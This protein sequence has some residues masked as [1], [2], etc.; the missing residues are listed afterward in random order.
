VPL[1]VVFGGALVRYKPADATGSS[2]SLQDVEGLT[3]PQLFK[4]MKIPEDQ[5]MLVI[6]NGDIVTAENKAHTVVNDGDNLSLMSPIQA[7]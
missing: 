1:N 6:L 5:P 7:G 4:Q 3:L 2:I